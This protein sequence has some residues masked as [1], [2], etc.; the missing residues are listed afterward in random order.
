MAKARFATQDCD[1]DGE[2]A[3]GG[4]LLHLLQVAG[5][6]DV[7]V[8]VSRWCASISAAHFYLRWM[9]W[10]KHMSWCSLVLR[11]HRRTFSCAQHTSQSATSVLSSKVILHPM[12]HVHGKTICTAAALMARRLTQGQLFK[13]VF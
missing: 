11:S 9:E 8:V 1:D 4:R 6:E 5:A 7:V 10:N 2:S 13:F 3:A 12:L